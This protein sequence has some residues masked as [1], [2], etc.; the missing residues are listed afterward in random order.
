[1]HEYNFGIIEESGNLAIATL[2][3]KVENRKIT[4]A[5]WIIARRGDSGLNGPPQAGQRGGGNLWD[6]DNLIAN[7]PPERVVP[8]EARL[9]REA[10][11][12]VTNS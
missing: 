6:P 5:E 4:E 10:M 9:S 11:I 2:R 1:M 12:G 8:K 7:A 3:L